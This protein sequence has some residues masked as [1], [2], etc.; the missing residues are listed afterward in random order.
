MRQGCVVRCIRRVV[1][2]CL[3]MHGVIATAL[4][5]P[6]LQAAPAPVSFA[7]LSGSPFSVGIKPT[8]VAIGDVNGD[9]KLDIVTANFSDGTVSVLLGNANGTL[10][11][12]ASVTVTTGS[13][14]YA[15]A[16]GDLNGDGK[17]DLA[18][19]NYGS[20]GVSVLLGNGNGTFSEASYS[21]LGVGANP[22]SIAISDVNGDHKPDLVTANY[23]S[24][25]VSVLIANSNTT[26][27]NAI[28]YSVGAAPRSIVLADVNN[29]GKSD[30]LVANSGS[31]T[32]SVLLGVGDG[33]FQTTLNQSAGT[34]PYAIAVGNLNGDT[35]PDLVVTNYNDNT[36]RVLLG[37]GDGTFTVASGAP[38]AVDTSPDAVAI[39][40]LNSDGMPDL[41]VANYG[42]ASVTIL[43]GTGDGT[44][45]PPSLPITVGQQPKSL[46][47]GDMNGD[48]T[49]DVI[50]V[51]QLDSSVTVL[52]NTT[53][54]AATHLSITAATN[55]STVGAPFSLT[56]TARTATNATATGYTHT[57][58]FTS[59]DPLATLP[60]DY[61]FTPADRGIHTFNTVIL[62]TSGNQTITATDT[63]STT[64]TG[65]I[66]I[67]VVLTST[68][69]T[70]TS[71]H[72]PAIYNQ[73][74][75]FTATVR[76]AS[77][78]SPGDAVN[79]LD[80]DTPI[81]AGILDANGQATFRTTALGVGNHAITARY[82]GNTA[83]APSTSP[84]FIQRVDAAAATNLV[85]SGFSPT[86][87]AGVAGSVTITVKDAFGNTA[88]GY[89]GTVHSSLGAND[90]AATLPTDYIFTNAD[91]G[92][93]TFSITL[94]KAGPQSITVTDVAVA[95]ITGSQGDITVT[96]AAAS[97]ITPSAGAT[98][99]VAQVTKP[100]A[101]AFAVTVMDA[102]NNPVG[103]VPIT[104]AAPT[105]GVSGT[106]ANGN[107]TANTSTNG[108]GMATAP[109]FTANSITGDY[110]VIARVNGVSTSASFS[111]SNSAGPPG[112]ITATMGAS[113]SVI[114]GKPFPILL[115][116]LVKDAGGNP[117]G[118]G[119]PVTFTA[120]AN[121]A[122]GVF[123]G[124]ITATV[125]TNG[126]GIATAPAF[127]ANTIAGAFAV[128]V[129]TPGVA[130]PATFDLINVPDAPATLTGSAGSGQSASVTT[131]FVT[132]LAAR[133]A[134]A[135]GNPIRD[136]AVTFTAPGSGASGTFAS[137]SATA[138][139]NTN[140][141]G[142]A[143]APPFTA[144]GTTGA[145]TVIA[146]ISGMHPTSFALTNL[147]GPAARLTL[148]APASIQQ[149]TSFMLMVTANDA[150]GNTAIGYTG[151]IHITSSDAQAI[152]PADAVLVNG[153]GA[154]VVT[155][156]RVGSQHVIATD[157]T[158]TSMTAGTAVNVTALPIIPNPIP[159]LSSLSPA[160]I[161]AGSGAFTL[162]I[163]GAG[164][165]D[166]SGVRWN[167]TP[168]PTTFVSS[169][170]LTI[171]LSASDIAVARS[172][173]VTAETAAPGGGISAA[174]IFAIVAVPAAPAPPSPPATTSAAATAS[175]PPPT[176][177]PV[178]EPAPTPNSAAPTSGSASM[179]RPSIPALVPITAFTDTSDH[180]FFPATNHSLNFGFKAFWEAKGGIVLFGLPISE[181]FT[182][183]GV[184]GTTRTVQYFERAR[185]EYHR[186]FSGTP[187]EVELGL[188][189]KEVT[190]GRTDESAFQPINANAVPSGGAF[191]LPTGHTLAGPVR[192][193]WEAN[194]G[195][196][197]FGLPISEPFPEVNTDTGQM[198]LVQYF[199]RYRIEY[200]AESVELGRLGVQDVQLRGYVINRAEP[201]PQR[202]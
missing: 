24:S 36:V 89:T 143:T 94:T 120:P 92:T 20:N 9:S 142:I 126:S 6:L 125:T 7:E 1:I 172:I 19:A 21:P 49:L 10:N 178:V 58:T 60:V 62:V 45:S 173:R 95:T 186:E 127:K 72:T 180:R 170:Q 200:H 104:F 164:F 64:T 13:E 130:T 25:N 133:V 192:A 165:V 12:A 33:T 113:Q 48:G 161:I 175:T 79:F 134:D 182:E 109:I 84:S 69:T 107:A 18:V 34:M 196:T 77:A 169:R 155:L 148:I 43:L 100:F 54:P 147:A 63:A 123:A 116:A 154:F 66:A 197:L 99:Q 5:P 194:G 47:I 108:S 115:T 11:A 67:S 3:L 44:F 98:H 111:L 106:F 184:D 70:L 199:E 55:S 57:V 80:T 190:A 181:E 128:A 195:L 202:S 132:A 16:I 27:Q 56:V 37:K 183:R 153:V 102:F 188:L 137:G 61:T 53:V 8:S 86:I 167:D 114:V 179:M 46:A 76:A 87:T 65:N 4:F 22:V 122:G 29:D 176:P 189:A 174:L 68:T 23:G 15:V 73:P 198:Y 82:S 112:T 149:N 193:F 81:G 74:I 177:A 201:Q 138:T 151:T 14:P 85:V 52:R 96:N 88:T 59:S 121:G 35:N 129:A 119:I 131:V 91:S 166:Q 187:Y 110:T 83:F 101:T 78:P 31:S 105:T 144:S 103:G 139:A 171:T 146:S 30:L 185:F 42:G 117:V 191:F 118:G 150:G 17:P 28:N 71:D 163:Y 97:S 136:V 93:H 145:Y 152:L 135:N 38:I 41:A 160:S 141:S 162:T 50:V 51:N 75:T 159:T 140:A 158:M 32:V 157:R 26:F 39:G 156:K 2:G 40:D 124:G 168:R 90:P